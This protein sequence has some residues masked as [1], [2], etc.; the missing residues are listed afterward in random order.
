ME[1]N[2]KRHHFLPWLDPYSITVATLSNK[3]QTPHTSREERLLDDWLYSWTS[4]SSPKLLFARHCNQKGVISHHLVSRETSQS[5][6][7]VG[8]VGTR[9]ACLLSDPHDNTERWIPPCNYNNA[10]PKGVSSFYSHRIAVYFPKLFVF[11]L[12][13]NRFFI[14][15]ALSWIFIYP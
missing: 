15:M 14:F 3:A 6:W 13:R 10:G 4:I 7:G 11:S 9:G 5:T 2:K 8:W 12:L 1:L